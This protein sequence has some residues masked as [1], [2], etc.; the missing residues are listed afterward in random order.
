MGNL[1]AFTL[2]EGYC[3][4]CPNIWYY[5]GEYCCCHARCGKLITKPAHSELY[6]WDEM[7]GALLEKYGE[8]AKVTAWHWR[9]LDWNG[10]D[11]QS[12]QWLDIDIIPDGPTIYDTMSSLIQKDC[13][14]L[15]LEYVGEEHRQRECVINQVNYVS[16][17]S[18]RDTPIRISISGDSM[19]TKYCCILKWLCTRWDSSRPTVQFHS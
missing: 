6:Y 7:E 10:Q 17:Q 2:P 13:T 1:C 14:K 18:W 5:I 19:C 12:T 9:G 8:N 16:S 3:I 4:C 11:G 15:V